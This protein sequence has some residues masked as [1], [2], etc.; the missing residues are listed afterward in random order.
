M[1]VDVHLRDVST[2]GATSGDTAF[3]TIAYDSLDRSA[4]LRGGADAA[5]GGLK[6]GTDGT[7]LTLTGK[8]GGT[9]LP[10]T[11]GTT[12]STTSHS[13]PITPASVLVLRV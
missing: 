7:R 2:G 10:V 8:A 11:V 6:T 4:G 1:D 9:G 12:L 3:V 5:V 13:L